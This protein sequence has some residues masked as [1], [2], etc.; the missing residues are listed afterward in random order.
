M[1]SESTR[2]GYDRVATQYAARVAGELEHK[3]LDRELLDRYAD[4][5]RGRGTV[6]DLGCG[7]G[8]VA[9]YL[10]ERGVDVVGVDLS[11]GMLE[12]ARRLN[13]GIE[14]RRGDMAA[15]DVADGAWAG[16]V[17]FYS[18]IHI[19]RE[20]MIG[21]LR[22]IRRVLRPGGPLFVAFHLGSETRHV[23][24]WWGEVVSL[25]FEFFERAEMET[26]LG[27][28]GFTIA[29]SVERGHYEG[30][31]VDTRRAYLLAR[32]PE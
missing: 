1:D 18:L 20:H 15:L 29:E 13:P 31:E 2:R 7:P 26:F 12:Q 25:D 11:E 28:A 9:R 5:V 21:V 6:C 17:A 19:P 3:P 24:D 4:A 30:V 27:E 32:K 22:E 14:F 23:D 8:H 10:H 16:I